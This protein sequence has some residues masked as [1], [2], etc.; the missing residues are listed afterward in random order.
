MKRLLLLFLAMWLVCPAQAQTGRIAGT[1]VDADTG[2]P[3]IGV[4]VFVEENST[5]TATD[6]EGRY[7]IGNLAPGTYTLRFSYVGYHSQT[8]AGVT[9]QAGNVTHLNIKLASQEV[10]LEAV[11]VEARLLR[12]TEAAMLAVRQKAAALSEA[13]SAEMM[14]RTGSNNAADA[15]EKVTGVSVL[16]GKYVYIRGLGERYMNAQ[17]NGLD[18][19]SADPDRKAVPF[20]LF[21]TALLDNIVTVKTFTPD[22]PGNFTGG[23][24]NLN[25]RAFPDALSIS[26]TTSITYR[27][28]VVGFGNLMLAVPNANPG[29]WG[30]QA[31]QLDVPALLQRYRLENIP[32]LSE[33]IV[34]AQNARL[35]D[36]L[37]KALTPALTPIYR[38]APFNRS[39]TL[40]VG[41]RLNLGNGRLLGVVASFSYRRQATAYD[42]GIWAR[43]RLTSRNATVL[44]EDNY[45]H[46]ISGTD[47][48][49]WGSLINATLRLHRHHELSVRFMQSHSA[50]ST[51]RYQRG[52]FLYTLEP[53][54]IYETRSLIYIE[55]N[56]RTYQIHGKH[57]LTDKEKPA[58][59]SW[60]LSITNTRQAEP[61]RRFFTN[62]YRIRTSSDGS[63]DTL[64]T[65]RA[66]TPP[67][68][69]F[70]SL[71]ASNQVGKLALD[72][73]ITTRLRLK[74][75]GYL[76]RKRRL[77]RE[78]KFVL[79]QQRGA[80]YN[81]NP[82]TFFTSENLGLIQEHDING[83]GIPDLF[84]F[85]LYLQED[86]QPSSNY[87]GL[88]DVWAGFAMIDGTLAH[89]LRVITGLRYE[90]TNME[91]VSHD[92]TKEA[93]RLQNGDWLPAVALIYQLAGNMNLR[94][95]YGRTLARPIFRELAPYSTFEYVGGYLLTGNPGLRRTLIDNV[96]L[97][98]EW[99]VRPGELLATSVFLKHF[100]NPI[101]AVYQPF[102]PNDSPEVQY[103]NVDDAV[104]YG[105]ELELRKRLD[106]LHG[107][108]RHFEISGNATL[109]HATVQVPAEELRSIRALRPDAPAT[110]PLQGQSPYLFNV[111]LSYVHEQRGTT[112]SLHYHVFRPRLK[113]VGLGGTPDT[114]ERPRH[115][116]DLNVSQR[117]LA[118]LSLKISA[119]NLLNA[120]YRVSHTYK[121][122]EYVTRAYGSG[123]A[124]SI[125]LRYQY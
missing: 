105:L 59:L 73:P 118:T 96:D 8:V 48:V 115:L 119:K 71:K 80:R 55:R 100:H 38:R 116:L 94:L 53:D 4:N 30:L 60:D 91:V 9:V 88:Q 23:S 120:R 28:Q 1:V 66:T 89:R 75:G 24:V 63:A 70:R 125:G 42:D 93:G 26:F 41:N 107:A 64:Y 21:P 113:E 5:G 124:F 74:L 13:I 110:R 114:Y 83:D 62:H 65:I 57:A 19:P 43:Y 51:A 101:E 78:R 40:S 92:S 27:P 72:I 29:T 31:S 99:F 97:R 95:A 106:F 86:T 108:L 103:R 49:L 123:R 111:N 87:D 17:L 121:G 85:G 112:V 58:T 22:K 54:D 47:E 102:A 11:V 2:E 44:S 56:L 7:E 16:D 20:D 36:Q 50:E 37:S 45:L 84:T 6:L 18:L 10:G 34:D 76:Q 12:N 32:S 25:T 68:R 98:W 14:A 109:V 35:L 69:Y 39:Y 3:L 33:A 90:T 15:M 104:L 122:R 82:E 61:D 67:Q 79:R 77:H 52:R 46:T 81:G 117:L